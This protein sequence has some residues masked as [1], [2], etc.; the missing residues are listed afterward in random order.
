M[1]A[2]LNGKVALI[3]G[4][5]SGIG[6]HLA[7]RF[8][9][10]GLRVAAADIVGAAAAATV[11]EVHATGAEALALEMDVT[12]ENQ[13]AAAF[14]RT[15]DVFHQVDV[16]ISNAGIQFIS[17]LIDLPFEEWQKLIAVHLDGAFL[18]ARATMRHLIDTKREGSIIFMGSIHSHKASAGK[19]A[20]I[21]AKH[22]L[23]GLTR[24]VAQEGGP[25]GVKSYLICPGFVDTPL[26]RNQIPEQSQLFGIS[27]ADVVQNIMLAGTVDHQFTTTDDIA[28]IALFLAAY[29]T[30]ALTGQAFVAAHGSLMH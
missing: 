28:E 25:V 23:A 30:N 20:Y 27:E 17:P 11:R 19:A 8:A 21:T 10:A 16:L 26:V 29:P 18:T 5:G 6:K 2:E 12:V 14:E 3:T 4:A 22:G 7:I 9:Q 1:L 13:V 15:L 24:A